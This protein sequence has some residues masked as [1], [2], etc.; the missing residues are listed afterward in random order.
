MHYDRP[1]IYE[2]VRQALDQNND[3]RISRNELKQN[4][5]RDWRGSEQH[6]N[7]SPSAFQRRCIKHQQIATFEFVQSSL[8]SVLGA[9][10]AHLGCPDCIFSVLLVRP[11]FVDK[12][13]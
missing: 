3:R 1:V 11:Q 8:D 7:Y 2:W 4:L 9:R 6:V 13:S 12:S 5:K 10:T